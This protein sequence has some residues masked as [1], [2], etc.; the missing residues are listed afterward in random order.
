[1]RERA[2]R[3]LFESP[4]PPAHFGADWA[5]T[6]ICRETSG[7]PPPIDRPACDD[8]SMRG[9]SRDDRDYTSASATSSA[10]PSPTRRWWGRASAPAP[11]R[12]ASIAHLMVLIP[13]ALGALLDWPWALT[14]ALGVPGLVHLIRLGFA[15]ARARGIRSRAESPRYARYSASVVGGASGVFADSFYDLAGPRYIGLALAG[16]LLA[17]YL[18][19]RLVWHL[20]DKRVGARVSQQA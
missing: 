14:V 11:V 2:V 20:H 17:V 16:V 1:M 6:E 8:G 15:A 4:R 3:L 13:A 5:G 7:A 9:P 12:S 10:S 19:D 18:I